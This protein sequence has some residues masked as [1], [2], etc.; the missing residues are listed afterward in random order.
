MA[1]GQKARGLLAGKLLLLGHAPIP[2]SVAEVTPAGIKLQ[3]DSAASLTRGVL[4]SSRQPGSPVSL[5][6][7]AAREKPLQLSAVFYDQQG[8]QVELH[9]PGAPPP[10]S[11]RLARLL[12]ELRSG[13]IDTA[14]VLNAL[15]AC[16]EKHTRLIYEDFLAQTDETLFLLAK[17]ARHFQLQSDLMAVR[18]YL[19]NTR[20]DTVKIYIDNIRKQIRNLDA[21]NQTGGASGLKLSL[22]ETTKLQDELDDKILINRLYEIEGGSIEKISLRFRELVGFEIDEEILPVSPQFLCRAFRQSLENLQL[23]T[24]RFRQLY[25]IY[26]MTLLAGIKAF[27]DEFNQILKEAGVLPDLEISNRQAAMIRQKRTQAQAAAQTTPGKKA[28]EPVIQPVRSDDRSELRYR[29]DSPEN[30]YQTVRSLMGIN[31]KSEHAMRATFLS[32]SPG[33]DELIDIINKI[34]ELPDYQQTEPGNGGIK[35]AIQKHL[36]ESSDEAKMLSIAHDDCIDLYEN[37]FDSILNGNEIDPAFREK[38][39][40][41]KTPFL[42]R[43]IV[44]D[45][46]FSSRNNA[47]RILLNQLASISSHAQTLHKKTVA[48]LDDAI[49]E[50][51]ELP[52]FDNEVLHR[53]SRE[54]QELLEKQEEIR[55]RHIHRIINSHQGTERLEMANREVNRVIRRYASEQGKLPVIIRDLLSI[56]LR[57]FLLLTWI[58]E[59]HQSDKWRLAIEELRTLLGW[60]Q[61]KP[62]K[63]LF[64]KR[65]EHVDN[66]DILDVINHLAENIDFVNPDLN[67]DKKYLSMLAVALL[68]RQYNPVILEEV[69]LETIN[70][71]RDQE[72]SSGNIDNRDARLL[73]NIELNDWINKPGQSPREA[74]QIIWINHDK[75]TYV[76]A[77]RIGHEHGVLSANA[78]ANLL[79]EGWQVNKDHAKV[80]AVDRGIYSTLQSVYQQLTYQ[81]SHDELTGLINRKEFERG[82]ARFVEQKTADH[83]DYIMLTMDL[84]QFS[85]INNLCGHHIGDRFLKEVSEVFVG[86]LPNALL[87]ARLGPNEFAAL[88]KDVSEEEGLQV[89]ETIRAK[90][91]Q[92]PFTVGDHPHQ[93]T[94]SLGLARFNSKDASAA[95]VFRRATAA[96]SMAKELG[97]DRVMVY[98]EDDRTVVQ[99][100][101]LEEWYPKINAAIKNNNLYLKAQRIAPCVQGGVEMP[102]YEVLLGLNDRD[103]KPIPIWQFIQ[104]AEYYKKM[105]DVDR[106]VINAVFEWINRNQDKISSLDCISINLSGTTVGDESFLEFLISKL[107][108]VNIDM[109]R[110]CFEVTETSAIQSIE[111]AISFI[112][113]VKNMG[114]QFSLDDFGTGFS[115]YEY[116][117]RLPVDYLKI[118]GVFIKN[119]TSSPDDMAVVKS[120]CEIGHYMNKKI[121]AEF[122]ETTQIWEMLKTLGVDYVQG[123]GVEMPKQIDLLQ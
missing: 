12:S 4:S 53:I 113:E 110:I 87:R 95:S 111:K 61:N 43:I 3:L 122:V 98:R 41:L 99:R 79:R 83:H 29:H 97:R 50:I 117:K 106:W 26:E 31:K 85:L 109:R 74:L 107:G 11:N 94:A 24:E 71:Y 103:N 28:P 20:A 81:R 72:D 17:D 19:R 15:E 63:Q 80:G 47:A 108:T 49:D 100:Q 13:R 67:E 22:V 57:Q 55:N 7:E 56:G 86:A 23:S 36:S 68:D 118:D 59:G 82:L 16:V 120:I 91:A 18:T 40:R 75:T 5:L 2:C 102:H 42:K 93:V 27:Y 70:E 96:C 35:Q 73:Q 116:L 32:S 66:N 64:L 39:L 62:D 119:L 76:L 38:I 6:V 10:E 25:V 46:F 44:D 54:I 112:T 84:D 88:L 123:F 69:G 34:S 105:Q 104:A 30:L 48:R 45:T 52:P 33:S 1:P 77:D 115:S 8:D 21:S 60:L 101:T 65:L 14:R 92:H 121:V 90:I 37:M 114:C 89:A 9:Y 51:I 58:N 78:L